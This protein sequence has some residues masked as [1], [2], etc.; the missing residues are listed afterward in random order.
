MYNI[1]MGKVLSTVDSKLRKTQ[2]FITLGLAVVTWC[3]PFLQYL[4]PVV[5]DYVVENQEFQCLNLDQAGE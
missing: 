1:K 4:L 2:F 5:S 3:P